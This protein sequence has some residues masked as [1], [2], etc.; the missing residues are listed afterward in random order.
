[1][2]VCVCVDL[3]HL[4]PP[5]FVERLEDVS[6]MVGSEI[7]MRCLL[8]G[9]LPMT[10]SWIKDGHELTEDEHVKMS[11]DIKGA[12]LNL[13]NA[14][15]LH[16][17]K[18]VC[19]AQNKAGTHRCAAVLTVTGLSDVFAFFRCFMSRFTIPLFPNTRGRCMHDNLAVQGGE[20]CPGWDSGSQ[21]AEV[22]MKSGGR[23]G[24]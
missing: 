14:Q 10:F 4:E 24:R 18:Y 23:S 7:F 2:F 9:T 12:I 3:L 11:Q 8:S 16:C 20:P 1:M 21:A 22:K 5:S 17:G 13:R 19:E 15:L 6:C